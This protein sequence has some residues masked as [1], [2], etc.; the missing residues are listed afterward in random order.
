MPKRKKINFI[1]GDYF[2]D[3]HVFSI[4]NKTITI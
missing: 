4:L 3:V 1:I 2:Q